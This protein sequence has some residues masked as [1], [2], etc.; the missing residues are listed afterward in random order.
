MKVRCIESPRNAVEGS[1]LYEKA[2][3]SKTRSF[4]NVLTKTMIGDTCW[5]FVVR[6]HLHHKL[7]MSILLPYRC[8][9]EPLCWTDNSVQMPSQQ[10]FEMALSCFKHI[11]QSAVDFP[12]RRYYGQVARL[13]GRTFSLLKRENAFDRGLDG[14]HKSCHTIDLFSLAK[15]FQSFK[16]W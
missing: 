13:G 15:H 10:S 12:R 9:P 7:A 11:I 3:S 8:I 6:S 5:R 4:T 1:A 2:A 16:Y 14:R